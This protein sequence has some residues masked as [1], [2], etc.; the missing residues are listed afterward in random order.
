MLR[1]S[2]S[3]HPEEKNTV[4]MYSYIHIT[5]IGKL[6]KSYLS[7]ARYTDKK[8]NTIFPHILGNSEGS[9]A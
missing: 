5:N 1:Q 6:L 2:K 4:S 3:I 8:E 9:G 7:Y